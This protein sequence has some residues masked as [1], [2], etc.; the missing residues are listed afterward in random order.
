MKIETKQ[1]F[2]IF[3]SMV[4]MHTIGFC[5]TLSVP[6]QKNSSTTHEGLKEDVW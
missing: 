2:S 6:F 3:L 5:E 4:S 1:W